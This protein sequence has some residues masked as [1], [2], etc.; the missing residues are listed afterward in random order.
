MDEGLRQDI[1]ATY[2]AYV[3]AYRVNDV[4]ALDGMCQ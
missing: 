2:S 4:S 1:L 3:E